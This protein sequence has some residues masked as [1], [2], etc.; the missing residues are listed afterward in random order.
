MY[1][2]FQEVLKC[3]TSSNVTVGVWVVLFFVTNWYEFEQTKAELY[4]LNRA[5]LKVLIKKYL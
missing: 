4:S 2:T 3:S 5:L 1:V